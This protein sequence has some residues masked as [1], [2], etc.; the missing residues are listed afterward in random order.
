MANIEPEVQDAEVVAEDT[1]TSKK[2]RDPKSFLGAIDNYFKISQSGSNFKTEIISGITT[3]MAMAYILLVN[4]GI[5][6]GPAGVSFGAIY[7]ATGLGAIVGTL[8]MSLYAKLPFAQAPGMGLNAYFAFTVIGTVVAGGHKMTYANA[9][10][11]ILLSGLLFLILTLVGAREAIIKSIPASVKNAI[12]AG[13]GLF[14]AFLGLQTAG[15]IVNDNSTLVAMISLNVLKGSFNV[16]W[17][18]IVTIISFLGIGVMAHHKIKGSI[19][20]GILGGSLLY[21]AGAGIHSAIVGYSNSMFVNEAG[22]NVISF[23]N[24]FLAFKDWGLQS[25]GKVFTDGFSG[26]FSKA[27]WFGDLMTILSVM[28]AFAMVDMFDTIGTLIGTAK[29]ANM[30]DKDGNVPNM[31]KALFADSVATVSGAVFGTSTV[32][33]FVES[34]AGVSEGGKTGFT[35][36]IVTACFIICL[37]LSPIAQ[38]IPGCATAAALVYVGVLMISGVKDIDFSDISVAVPA[39]LTISM[40]AFTYNISYGIALGLISHVIIKLFSGIIY[41]CRKNKDESKKAFKEISPITI[42]ISILFILMFLFTH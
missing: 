9:L 4:P 3:F 25:V 32:T 26:L 19:L 38:L 11:I 41:A 17:P 2:S 16:L 13:I 12:P 14:I 40:M 28:L 39:F 36:L 31:R 1:V 20:W 22:A 27:T 42:I 24:P 29:K 34:S 21:Y 5:I 6:S 18:A 37:F 23:S 30:L 15:I 35:S 10:V 8:I 33:T 7:I